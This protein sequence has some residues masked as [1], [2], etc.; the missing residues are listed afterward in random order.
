MV[1]LL[2][3]RASCSRRLPA[4]AA[5]RARLPC[6]YGR[7]RAL[8]SVCFSSDNCRGAL[9]EVLQAVVDA[10]APSS[11]PSYG[12]DDLTT[13]A[14]DAVRGWLGCHPEA[15]V[16]P[17]ISG[18]ASDVL[19][20]T[21]YANPTTAVYVHEVSHMHLWQC[22]AA[23]FYT[24]AMLKAIGGKHGKIDPAQLAEALAASTK[25]RRAV[26]QPSAAVVSV[27]QPTEA[28]TLYTIEELKEICDIAH[29]HGVSVHMDG[30]RLA[31]AV[32]A[33][34]CTPAEITWEAGVDVLALGT[35]KGGTLA[36]EA[37]VFFNP[38]GSCSTTL[39]LP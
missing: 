10:N 37:V 7:S 38:E 1:P 33:L 20:L 14:A 12:A 31:N 27:T 15:A 2:R 25:A 29:S 18:I 35:T 32:V 36:A 17:T 21:P 28:G 3:V 13:Q 39:F 8:S 6:L 22:G 24:G 34:G 11:V 5:S 23:G 26:Y 9:P 30:A 16:V 19:G 4:A